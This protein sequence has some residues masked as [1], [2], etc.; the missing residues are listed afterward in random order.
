MAD[1]KEAQ[2]EGKVEFYAKFGIDIYDYSYDNDTEPRQITDECIR[3]SIL[4]PTQYVT[5]HCGPKTITWYFHQ[6]K[7]GIN[8][9]G[10]EETYKND[11]GFW[12]AGKRVLP[13]KT[14]MKRFN[15]CPVSR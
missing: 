14:F 12:K 2:K 13:S 15:F 3:L 8:S 5:C 11:G 9:A 4:E 1:V 7:P 10:A 6:R